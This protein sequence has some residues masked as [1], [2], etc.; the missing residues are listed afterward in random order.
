MLDFDSH[1]PKSHFKQLKHGFNTFI[2]HFYADD[3]LA[4]T[5]MR[6]RVTLK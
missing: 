4:N 2:P 6:L 5:L 1:A 3:T